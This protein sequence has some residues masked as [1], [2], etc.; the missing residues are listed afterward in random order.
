MNHN[1]STVDY[2]ISR[3]FIQTPTN[4]NSASGFAACQRWWVC[5]DGY[6]EGFGGQSSN[7]GRCCAGPH[8]STSADRLAT[9]A[10]GVARGKAAQTGLRHLRQL[11]PHKQRS[12][13]GRWSPLVRRDGRPRRMHSLKSIVPEVA[14][15]VA[16]AR[17][18]D[19]GSG[20]S[21]Q[22][23]CFYSWHATLAAG[24]FVC[25]GLL[26]LD[27]DCDCDCNDY[28]YDHDDHHDCGY[29]SAFLVQLSWSWHAILVCYLSAAAAGMRFWFPLFQLVAGMRF[30]FRL[31]LA[32]CVL[33][34]GTWI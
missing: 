32:M 20:S 8:G 10:V 7:T 31:L 12:S 26:Q 4:E 1:A 29:L 34:L 14:A 11:R 3:F 19:Q 16:V 23:R 17:C 27:C 5:A 28:D 9:R 22:Q 30:C 2:N 33:L 21:A 15:H 24:K 13:F 6:R 25:L 18:T